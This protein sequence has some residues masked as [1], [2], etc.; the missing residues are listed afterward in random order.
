MESRHTHGDPSAAL[1]REA[2]AWLV[3]LTSGQATAADAEAFRQW[4]ERSPAHARAFAEAR[5]LWDSLGPAARSV[6]DRQRRGQV[7]SY[8]GD[9]GIRMTRRVFLGGAVAASAA[10][11]IGHSPVS[12]WANA[13]PDYRT[14]KGE[15]RRVELANGVAVEMNTQTSINV[16]AGGL[17][18]ELV[19][20][21]AVVTTGRK[22][23]QPFVVKAEGGSVL[24]AAESEC[25][26]RCTGEGVQ[27][28]CLDG[29][30]ELSC[31]GRVATVK[32]SQQVDYDERGI[33]VAMA[34]NP[35]IAMSWRR[36]VLIF[37]NQPLSDVI[38]D[39]NRY[40]PGKIILTD[41]ALAARKVHA[42]FSLDQM[43][44]VTS[45]IRD[46][47]G[48]RVTELPGGIVLLS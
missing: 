44:D 40:R 18:I 27:V 3:Q 48:A 17:G 43:A 45:L 30:T 2:R 29:L 32:P 38:D 23:S 15:Q 31:A 34:V 24:A 4:C 28:T 14:A 25:N 42:R 20:G 13:A 22:L 8:R 7:R 39:I 41:A 47:Y 36:R 26:V 10:F 16:L 1:H 5:A 37:D 21:E 11:V 6:A 19:S 46:A 12:P 33:G 9:H 35:D